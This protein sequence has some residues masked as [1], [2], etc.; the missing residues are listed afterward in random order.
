MINMKKAVRVLVILII[1]FLLV[2]I[3]SQTFAI[4]PEKYKPDDPTEQEAKAMTDKV[5]IILGAVRN[6]SVVVSVI[7]IMIIGVKYMLASVQEKARY[8]E[9]MLPYIIGF[10]MAIVGATLVSYIYSAVH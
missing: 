7:A 10:L 1:I 4:D 6:I 3:C 9:T 8:K 5:E 2:S